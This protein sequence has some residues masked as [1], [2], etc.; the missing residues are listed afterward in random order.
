MK[1]RQ[2]NRVT[3]AM[4]WC[5]ESNVFVP[6]EQWF[7][8]TGAMLESINSGALEIRERCFVLSRMMLLPLQGA[9]TPT[10]HHPGR[11]P[12]LWAVSLTG[13]FCAICYFFTNVLGC[14]QIANCYPILFHL[15]TIFHGELR[16]F[17]RWRDITR[18]T[19]RWR[20]G[21]V[22]LLPWLVVY[23]SPCVL[24]WFCCFVCLL[25][26]RGRSAFST[27]LMTMWR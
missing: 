14:R 24:W 3:R 4:V 11:C 19:K 17:D 12:G 13:R 20:G 25:Q 26:R 21:N 9:K 18:H 6:R 22:C 7:C 10:P 23:L 27:W 8:A 5:H 2:W 1:S 16:L 15:S